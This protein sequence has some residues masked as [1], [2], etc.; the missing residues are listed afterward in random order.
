MPLVLG[1]ADDFPYGKDRANEADVVE[2]RAATIGVV[3]GKDITGV[4]IACKLLEY[5]L[6]LKV[7]GADVYR[8]VAAALH[9]RVALGIAQRG[10]EVTRVDDEGVAGAQ[11]L[12]AHQVDAGGEG[13][14]EDFEGDRIESVIL[15]GMCHDHA[16]SSG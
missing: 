7:Q 11:N 15:I 3:D 9:D 8:D 16:S 4:N 1:K 10:G 13:V 14:L 5:R 2:V 6:A 12:L